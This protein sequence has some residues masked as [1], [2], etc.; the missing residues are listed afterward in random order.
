MI[1]SK[2]TYGADIAISAEHPS[3]TLAALDC[4]RRGGS[5][6]DAMIAASAVLA[7]VLPHAC[8]LGGEGMVLIRDAQSSKIYGL[9]GAGRAPAGVDGAFEAQLPQRGP[10]V[11]ITPTLVRLWYSAHRKFGR[12]PMKELLGPAR[13]IAEQG[14]FVP[15]EMVHNLTRVTDDIRSQPGFDTLFSC[16]GRLMTSGDLMK[17]EA[18]ARVFDALSDDG[19]DAFYRG[20][21]MRSMVDWLQGHGGLL[22]SEDLAASAAT[23]VDPMS[24]RQHGRR[25]LAMPPNSG[26]VLMLKHLSDWSRHT[27]DPQVPELAARI[28]QC[29]K[30]IAAHRRNIGSDI[31]DSDLG[32]LNSTHNGAS[33]SPR[34]ADGDANRTH[35]DIGDTA[36]FCAVDAAGNMVALLQSVFQPFG[37]GVVDPGTGI[38]FNN[39]IYDFGQDAASRSRL[40]AGARPVHTLN[41]WM[42][43][44]DD[45]TMLAGA[46]P[47]GISQVVTGAQLILASRDNKKTLGEIVCAPRWST[48][49]TG[50]ILLESGIDLSI[51]EYLRS[52][53]YAVVEDSSHPFYFG[54]AQMV[55]LRSSCL[56][57]A[58]DDHRDAVALAY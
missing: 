28:D 13:R 46:S 12:T 14:S 37:S 41:P 35:V 39:R 54:S 52:A 15:E 19:E 31:S 55:R 21:I 16:D 45:G 56:E 50:E 6:V 26:G 40:K 20:P 48:S 58:A 3:A 25:V 9:N 2:S 24:V 8:S 33:L 47:G 30:I 1:R 27:L 5:M 51:A 34:V 10:S 43:V 42:V 38:L 18:L 32:F 57:A 44:D 29:V 23:W 22:S 4:Y 49:R 11:C 53:G 7:T 17:Q 36:A